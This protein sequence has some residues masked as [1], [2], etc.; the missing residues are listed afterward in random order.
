[1]L[2]NLL[3]MILSSVYNALSLMLQLI[4]ILPICCVFLLTSKLKCLFCKGSQRGS[5]D[6][7]LTFITLAVVFIILKLTGALD[8]IALA[9]GYTRAFGESGEMLPGALSP[10]GVSNTSVAGKVPQAINTQP[11]TSFENLIDNG[12][13]T[14]IQTQF[15]TPMS[16]PTT[17]STTTTTTTTTP[18]P[19][20]ARNRYQPLESNE[21]GL[22]FPIYYNKVPQRG[23]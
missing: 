3:R 20:I 15:T 6:C 16:P 14:P 10:G 19:P 21:G 9:F 4:S 17:E 2:E 5:G 12:F 18:T 22:L 13:E 23:G 11:E 7:A 8:S 1:M